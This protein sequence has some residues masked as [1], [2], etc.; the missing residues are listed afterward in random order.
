[1]AP[2]DKLTLNILLLLYLLLHNT[3]LKAEECQLPKAMDGLTLILSVGEEYSYIGL[4]ENDVIEMTF[5]QQSYR[6][7]GHRK[8]RNFM[9]EYT[10]RK[11]TSNVAQIKT[12][13]FFGADI[14]Q[15][16]LT[17]IC[18]TGYE[19][20]YTYAPTAGKGGPQLGIMIERY[21]IYK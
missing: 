1:M 21:V 12:R 20:S 13:E 15:Y 14:L 5:Y 6:A 17:L 10:Y 3:L 11:L 18:E 9:G 16:S 8:N 19:G 7:I 2:T 4:F